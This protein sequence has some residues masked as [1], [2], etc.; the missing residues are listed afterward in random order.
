MTAR[1]SSLI[2]SCEGSILLGEHG[3]TSG[4]TIVVACGFALLGMFSE[5]SLVACLLEILSQFLGSL[6]VPS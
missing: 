2:L 3:V 6:I 4:G 5:N 1:G